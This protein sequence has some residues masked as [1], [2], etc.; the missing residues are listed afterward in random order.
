MTHADCRAKRRGRR[1]FLTH[2]SAAA[3]AGLLLG[4]AAGAAEQP[5]AP[6]P[7]IALGRHRVTRLIAG[8]NPISGYSYLG[9]E[10]DQEMKSYF[11]P[12]RTLTFLQQ[13]ERA[14]LDTHQYSAASKAT[15]VYRALR[16]KGSKLQLIGLH[17]KREEIKTMFDAIQPIAI[18]HHGGVTDR[19]FKE[20]T[21]AGL[22][23][24][25]RRS[26]TR[27]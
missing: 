5:T 8:A 6:L 10:M 26:T 4:D 20:G 13:C 16:E 3:A 2:C 7:T 24:S 1:E 14:G 9:K 12:E 27:G 22:A 15:E 19:F 21:A 25:S 11:T 17:S 23:T 18:V